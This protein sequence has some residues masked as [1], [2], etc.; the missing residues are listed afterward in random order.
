MLKDLICIICP[1]GCHLIIDENK[2]VTGNFCPRGEKYALEEIFAPKRTITSTVKVLTSDGY[3]RV[4]VK[5]NRPIKK[6]KI[7][8]VMK[9]IDKIVVRTPLHIGDVVIK[10]VL[11]E[12]V[13]IIITKNKEN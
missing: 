3:S 1:R 9:E 12:D 5:T 13:D 11:G 2:K 10:N 6:E 7:F 8:D 4:S